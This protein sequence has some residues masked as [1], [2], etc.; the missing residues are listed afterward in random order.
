M[1]HYDSAQR[2]SREQNP[3]T[4][5]DYQKDYFSTIKQI[6]IKKLTS[7]NIRQLSSMDPSSTLTF[8]FGHIDGS[9]HFLW[10]HN[11]FFDKFKDKNAILHFLAFPEA[12]ISYITLAIFL[13]TSVP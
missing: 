2:R 12:P 9:N 1:V 8:S 11:N 7:N 13:L 3:N 10:V 5:S 4:V 6:A